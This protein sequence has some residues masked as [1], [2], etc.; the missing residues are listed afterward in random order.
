MLLILL[1]LPTTFWGKAQTFLPLEHTD[2]S[3]QNRAAGGVESSQHMVQTVYPALYTSSHRQTE[4]LWLEMY[5]IVGVFSFHM[6]EDATECD[7]CPW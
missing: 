5:V 7:R 2:W 3:L 4:H 1:M 6:K